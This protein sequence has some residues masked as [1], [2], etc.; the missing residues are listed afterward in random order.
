MFG[1]SLARLYW[2]AAVPVLCGLPFA[3]LVEYLARLRAPQGWFELALHLAIA[4]ILYF[5]TA[6]WLV[7]PTNERQEWLGRIR[8]LVLRR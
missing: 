1:T 3:A 2:A 7:F 6:G 5:A 8:R 4:P